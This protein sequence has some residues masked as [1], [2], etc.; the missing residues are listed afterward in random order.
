M[1]HATNLSNHSQPLADS[2]VMVGGAGGLHPNHHSSLGHSLLGTRNHHHHHL[3]NQQRQQHQHPH[4]SGGNHSLP[5]SA[6][7]TTPQ[8]LHHSMSP[9]AIDPISLLAADSNHSSKHRHHQHHRNNPV[10]PTIGSQVPLE[11]PPPPAITS[12]SSSS[13]S[14]SSTQIPQQMTI[15]NGNR[16]NNS[17]NETNIVN[18]RQYLNGNSPNSVNSMPNPNQQSNHHHQQHQQQQQ[19][20]QQQQLALQNQLLSMLP[21]HLASYLAPFP[22][23]FLAQATFATNGCN[24]LSTLINSA[25]NGSNPKVFQSN[26]QQLFEQRPVSSLNLEELCESNRNFL[27][28]FTRPLSTSSSSYQR[29]NSQQSDSTQQLVND[30]TI[31]NLMEKSSIRNDSKKLDQNKSKSF[32]GRDKILS[33]N[34]SLVRTSSALSVRKTTPSTI[35]PISATV[36]SNRSI[37]SKSKSK[38]D[39]TRLAQSATEGKLKENCSDENHTNQSEKDLQQLASMKSDDLKKEKNYEGPIVMTHKSFISQPNGPF[40]QHNI[41]ANKML[42]LLNGASP[43]AQLTQDGKAQTAGSFFGP[44]FSAQTLLSTLQ[45]QSPQ[46]AD[47][48]SR[49]LARVNRISSRPKKE[50]ICRYCQRRFTKSYNLLIHERTHT[51]ERP[52]TCDICNKAF[53]RQDHLRDHRYIHSKEKPFKCTECGKGFCQ[54]RTLAV[55]RILHMDDSPHKCPTCGRSFNQRSNLKTHLLT[56]TDIKP[57]NCSDCGKEFRRN[58]DLRRHML[59]HSFGSGGGG[60][61]GLLSNDNESI[62]HF[63]DRNDEEGEEEDDQSETIKNGK[64]NRDRLLEGEKTRSISEPNGSKQYGTDRMLSNHQSNQNPVRGRPPLNVHRQQQTLT[65][66]AQ[67]KNID[68]NNHRR[69]SSPSS[70][71][72]SNQNFV[73]DRSKSQINSLTDLSGEESYRFDAENDDETMIAE[74]EEEEDEDCD[75]NE[76][77][78]DEKVM[79]ENNMEDEIGRMMDNEDDDDDDVDVDVDIDVVNRNETNNIINSDVD[80]D[81]ELDESDK[82]KFHQL[83]KV[84]MVVNQHQQRQQQQQQQQKLNH[85]PSTRRRSASSMK[86]NRSNRSSSTPSSPT[87]DSRVNRRYDGDDINS[88]DRNDLYDG[89]DK[90]RKFPKDIDLVNCYEKNG[91][92]RHH[93]RWNSTTNTSV[94]NTT[95]IDI[96]IKNVK[97]SIPS[98]MEKLIANNSDYLNDRDRDHDDGIENGDEDDDLI[99]VEN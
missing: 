93:P 45:H 10:S 89:N 77:R 14:S 30:K 70:L 59:T 22:A 66:F 47:Y 81:D 27:M 75:D 37:G 13:S 7:P 69:Q 36:P 72:I 65:V 48:F 1:V 86:S 11:P 5:L 51:D 84:A 90:V 68:R 98:R 31:A 46:L 58:C 23:H 80:V 28:N 50:F 25:S 79:V 76:E 95:A 56:H 21:N 96:E 34:N 74:E 78:N 17:K 83:I 63:Q 26:Q 57:Y 24:P 39:F 97:K 40:D 91:N 41:V 82:K 99:D 18:N 8:S 43:F 9:P 38:F 87:T 53:R 92:Q 73:S 54:S 3:L 88:E 55:H 35:V 61:G 52:Y 64:N 44:N 85:Q 12:S 33:D 60:G 49:K 29:N 67:T 42:T 6:L 4:L 94:H 62:H 71:S 16:L 19:Q 15:I 32:G 2:I 20:Q